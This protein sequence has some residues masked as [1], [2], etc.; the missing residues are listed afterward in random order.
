[1][2]MSCYFIQVQ[3]LGIHLPMSGTQVR[4]LVR[5]DLTCCGATKPVGSRACALQLGKSSCSPQLEKAHAQQQPQHS[6]K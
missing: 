5:E 1:M 3:W 4:F 2:I 6:Q